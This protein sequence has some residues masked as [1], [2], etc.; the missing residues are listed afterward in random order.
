MLVEP[1]VVRPVEDLRAA[2]FIAA[3]GAGMSGIAQLFA[4]SGVRV[5]GSD[6]ADSAAL[7]ALAEAG[8]S[9][10]V[11]HAAEQVGDVDVVVVSSAIRPDTSVRAEIVTPSVP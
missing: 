5:S 11:G 2:H 1:V 9:V 4:E 10:R 3:G 7:R 6:Q 8:L